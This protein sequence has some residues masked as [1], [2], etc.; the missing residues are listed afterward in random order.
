MRI[1]FEDKNDMCILH[2]EGRFV[3]GSDAEFLRTREDLNKAGYRKVLVDC[4]G[5]TYMDST[6]LNF[7]VGLYTS[8][9]N[10]GGRF[11]LMNLN[12]RVREVLRIT[13]LDEI[14]PIFEDEQAAMASLNSPEVKQ[15]AEQT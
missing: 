11:G 3:S 7:V 6:A 1:D 13:H 14:I 15:R 8:M 9:M 5:V 4:H 12:A 2:L 10:G